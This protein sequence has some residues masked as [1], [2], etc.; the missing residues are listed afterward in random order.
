M[1][2]YQSNSW[3]S[4]STTRVGVKVQM[5]QIT[6]TLVTIVRTLVPDEVA[7]CIA[8]NMLNIWLVVLSINE[9]HSVFFLPLVVFRGLMYNWNLFHL[10]TVNYTFYLSKDKIQYRYDLLFAHRANLN[11]HTLIHYRFNM[12]RKQNKCL[13]NWG[14]V[15]YWLDIIWL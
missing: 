7:P 8:H 9:G 14:G 4:A 12:S 15:I 10:A 11:N 6:F 5:P 13:G 2:S 3:S 1:S